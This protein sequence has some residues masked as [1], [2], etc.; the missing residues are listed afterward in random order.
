M[1]IRERMEARGILPVQLAD[2]MG[3]SPSAVNKWVYS[4][5]KGGEAD[6]KRTLGHGPALR[7][8][9]FHHPCDDGSH[10]P[11]SVLTARLVPK[12]SA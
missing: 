3:V 4:P 8:V 7:G 10:I 11:K 6:G 1:R 2:A 12:R 9:F 5:M